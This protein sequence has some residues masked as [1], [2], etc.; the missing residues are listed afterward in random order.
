VIRPV[1]YSYSPSGLNVEK[2][3]ALWRGTN[4]SGSYAA[5]LGL[6][7]NM[8]IPSQMNHTI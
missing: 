8:T 7:R 4:A 3:V 5:A 1:Q 6:L 2:V